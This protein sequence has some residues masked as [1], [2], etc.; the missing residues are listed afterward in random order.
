MMVML[1]IKIIIQ[2]SVCVF[3]AVIVVDCSS[4]SRV[5]FV[6]VFVCVCVCVCVCVSV[7]ERERKREGGGWGKEGER[8]R[9]YFYV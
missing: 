4:L 5:V 6:C 8:G 9:E 1:G 2:S 3:K 7:R